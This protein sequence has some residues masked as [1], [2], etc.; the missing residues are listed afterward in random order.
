MRQVITYLRFSSK[1]QERGDSLRRQNALFEQWLKKNPDTQVVDTFQDE[2]QS[3]FHGKHL[4]GEFGRMLQSIQ[5]GKYPA[6]RTV[7]LVES[8]NRLNRQKAR[9]TENLVD[10]ITGKGIDV[11]CLESG[12]TYNAENI[13]ELGTSIQLKIAAHI[14]YT[15]SKEKSDKVSA[16]WEERTRLAMEGKRLTKMVPGWI[17][18]ETLKLNEHA[19]TVKTVFEL[20]LAGE[21]LHNIARHLQSNNIKAFSRRKDAN[22]FSVHSV[23]TILTSESTIGTLAASKH[24]SRPA[25]PDY[26]AAAV[27]VSTF[28]K[29]QEILSKNRKGRTPASDNPVTINLFKGLMRCECGSSVHPTGVKN[30][31][32]GVYRCNHKVDGRCDIPHMNRKPFDQWMIDNIVGMLEQ[33]IDDKPGKR[34][35]EIEYQI[36]ILSK[37]IKKAPSILLGMEVE[38]DDFAE[39]QEEVNKL[40][41]K[42]KGLRSELDSLKHHESLSDKVLPQLVDLDLTTKTGRVEAQLILSKYILSIVLKREMIVIT[43]RNGCEIGKSRELSPIASRKLI[44]AV[45]DSANGKDIDVVEILSGDE[46]FRKSGRSLTKY[47]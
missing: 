34:I 24:N 8:E 33:S 31:Y 13:D 4:K 22:G 14:A 43:L 12:K 29:A 23:R 10:L 42:R 40:T 47:K 39:F 15:Q 5:D 27:D 6:G 35:A 1:P 41:R 11:I 21:S 17:D 16:A 26:Y 2:G 36:D 32:Q 18:P 7:L 37:Q 25:I 46:D 38:S 3:A 9:K 44:K 30:T 28:N 45:L 19:L 20:L